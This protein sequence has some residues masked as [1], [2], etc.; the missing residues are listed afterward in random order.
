MKENLI[1]RTRVF[2]KRG[3]VTMTLTV[4]VEKMNSIAHVSIE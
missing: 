1:V 4:L 3:D 2:Q